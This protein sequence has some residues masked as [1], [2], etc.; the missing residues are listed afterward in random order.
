MVYSCIYVREDGG[1]CVLWYLHF[2]DCFRADFDRVK[3]RLAVAGVTRTIERMNG[4]RPG[5]NRIRFNIAV[6]IKEPRRL[7]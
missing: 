4:G 5:E 2:C 6:V 1:Y 7:R 3:Y